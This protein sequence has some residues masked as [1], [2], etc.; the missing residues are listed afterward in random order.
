MHRTIA[1]VPKDS[2]DAYRNDTLRIQENYNMLENIEKRLKG[3]LGA[4]SSHTNHFSE[5]ERFSLEFPH[6]EQVS[7]LDSLTPTDVNSIKISHLDY[8]SPPTKERN[9]RAIPAITQPILN[10]QDYSFKKAS[11]ENL[12]STQHLS[13]QKIQKTEEASE[14]HFKTVGQDSLAEKIKSI[15]AKI[16]KF[17]QENLALNP[18]AI[19]PTELSAFNSGR[20]SNLE[21][22]IKSQ[23]AALTSVNS[24]DGSISKHKCNQ[25]HIHHKDRKQQIHTYS[26]LHPIQVHMDHNTRHL[27]DRIRRKI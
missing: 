8:A 18:V 5:K 15:D 11:K 14:R 19:G 4:T 13:D 12:K 23:I 2:E 25:R 7:N 1:G 22:A 6:V 9:T 20:S 27:Q 10:V 3:Y 17:K 21:M 16:N 26:I 24:R